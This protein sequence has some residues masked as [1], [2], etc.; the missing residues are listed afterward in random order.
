MPRKTAFTVSSDSAPSRMSVRPA[1]IASRPSLVS[2]KKVCF[3][4]SQLAMTPNPRLA[5]AIFDLLESEIAP[6]SALGRTSYGKRM[7]TAAFARA[8]LFRKNAL[9]P[10]GRNLPYNIDQLVRVEGLDQPSG[11]AGV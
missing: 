11:R 6:D 10:L 2:S 5:R 9:T 7:S 8:D 3:S 4:S 1:S